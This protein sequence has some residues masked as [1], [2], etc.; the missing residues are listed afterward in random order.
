MNKGIDVNDLT[1]S[2]R[3]QLGLRKQREFKKVPD[4]VSALGEILT[5]TKGMKTA[6]AL[7]A[8]RKACEH[9]GGTM[10]KDTRGGARSNSGP[11][12]DNGG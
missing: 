1:P 11:K 5:V 4:R 10:T 9:L 3:K 7:W 8:I 2:Q 12:K 6:D